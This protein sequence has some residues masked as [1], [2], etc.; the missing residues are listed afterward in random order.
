MTHNHICAPLSVER[1]DGAKATGHLSLALRFS[2]VATRAVL[3]ELPLVR[4]YRTFLSKVWICNC[5]GSSDSLDHVC[6]SF[7]YLDGVCLRCVCD[8]ALGCCFSNLKNLVV[9][10]PLRLGLL[11]PGPYEFL[12]GRL[13][14]LICFRLMTW[15]R[16]ASLNNRHA[17][18]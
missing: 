6:S 12:D 17:D 8:C 2:V 1:C 10:L 11:L 7:C 18:A 5:P 3:M 16:M 4:Q 15:L 13:V 14:E 9:T